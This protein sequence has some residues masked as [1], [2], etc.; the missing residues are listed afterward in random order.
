[1]EN[2]TQ[3]IRS[4][5]DLIFE[6][7]NKSYGAY[8]IRQTYSNELV[9]GLLT[10]IGIGVAMLIVIGFAGGDKLIDTVVDKGPIIFDPPP[11]V[12]A[13]IIPTTKREPVRK[14]NR[15]LPP[16]AVTEPDPVEPDPKPDDTTTGTDGSTEGTGT[17]DT[18]TTGTVDTGSG[19]GT[20]EVKS[21]E[22]FDGVEVMPVYRTGYEGMIKVL[23]KNMRY[24][25]SAQQMGKE[26]TV[27]VQFVVNDAG[28]I[29]DVK[30]MRGFDKDCDKEAVR[31][32]EKLTDWK[33]GYQNNLAVNVR[34]VIPI[35]FKIEPQ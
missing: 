28:E 19:L 12:Q 2:Q 10:T 9:K 5:D 1:M 32:V 25:R 29:R 26:G 35:K 24:P 18:G 13:E 14:V 20:G 6:N 4:W 31:I 30:V 27:Y 7:R 11:N 22:P 34:L 3:N 8:A 17:T 16:V 33:P 15:D 23:K 21:N